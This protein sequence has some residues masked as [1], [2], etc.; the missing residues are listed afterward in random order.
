MT[1]H[2]K[3]FSPEKLHTEEVV[4][5][6]IVDQLVAGQG[7][8]ERPAEAFDQTLGLDR[9]VVVAFVKDTQPQVWEALEGQYPGAAEKEFFRNLEQALK[10]RGTLEV[11]R[12][13]FKMVPNMHF[14]LMFPRPASSLNPD[15]V[16]LYEGNRLTVMTQVVYS[17]RH[18]NAIDIVLFLNGLPVATMEVKNTL[19]S[20]TFR[21]AES[22]YRKDRPPAGEPLLTFKRGALVHFALDQEN[23]SMTT[24]LMNGKTRFLPFN[25]GR[26]GGAGNPDIEGDFA[27]GYLYADQPEGKAIFGREVWIDLMSKFIH[28]DK[29]DG[30]QVMLFPRF[31]QLDCVRKTLAHARAHGPGHNYL[32]Q[33][34]AGSGKSNTIAWLAH[35]AINLHDDQNRP[36]FDT[37]IIITDRLVLDRQLQSTVASFEKTPGVVK[38]I[39]GTSRDLRE[40]IEAGARIIITTI[41]K[42]GTEHLAKLSGVNTRRFAIIIDEAHSSQ[43]GKSN[44]QMVRSLTRSSEDVEDVILEYQRARGPQPNISFFAF[45]ATP[46]PVTLERFGR[47]G[48]DGTPQAFHLYS[49]RQAIE[50]GFI[51]DVLQNYTTYQAYFQLEKAIE[52]DPALRTRDGQRR[53]ARFARL[54]P[55]NIAQ[56]VEV[57]VEHFRRHVMKELNG[58][59]KAMVVTESREHALRYWQ[60]LK[61]Y[62]EKQGYTDLKA[63]VAFSGDLDID[64]QTWSE[65]AANGFS[66]GELPKR[67]NGIKPDGTPYEVQYQVLVVAEK[68]QT[69][70][71]QPKLCAMYVD[72]KLDGLQAVQTLARLNRTYPGK[73]RTF[74]L[75]FRNTLDDIRTAFAPFFE[76]TLLEERTNFNQIYT[77][78][79]QIRSCPQIDM[80]EVEAF[81]AGFFVGR[82]LTSAERTNLEAVVRRARDRFL[83]A[84]DE[85]AMEEFRQFAKSY[86][87][88]Y[89]FVSQVVALGDSNLERLYVYLDWLVRLLPSRSIPAQIEITDDML[90][91]EAYRIEK[92][93]EGSASLV[94]GDGT[95]L[96]PIEEFGASPYTEEEERSLS[97]IVSAFNE[98]HG[99]TFSREDFLRLER[100]NQEILEDEDLREMILNN[101]EDVVRPEFEALFMGA[102]IRMFQRD[103]EMQ[104][105][106]MS[107][108]EAREMAIRHFFRTARRQVFDGARPPA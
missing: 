100:V 12:E 98:R 32:E 41:Q 14:R 59:A 43:S 27:I 23:V 60:G 81:A 64:G 62:I 99:T 48:P 52:D 74:V 20:Q 28:L 39:D 46:R 84:D 85:A 13:G 33:H 61:G 82:Q 70:F 17:A 36:I 24:R 88:F 73:D 45:T 71:D 69:G 77:L 78:E 5:R 3:S 49:M 16:R 103:T 89:A 102:L 91:L 15:L 7:Y 87:R 38:K 83:L 95:R 18:G 94:A 21:H 35:Q 97:E 108:N 47:I 55:T 50:E 11:L 75:D 86:M 37:A 54:H 34:S 93:D 30:K 6:H 58:Q 101:P 56:K 65:E 76:A 104:S 31:Q 90:R 53:V 44:A 92:T 107:D 67:F 2:P 26:D 9:D 80:S 25:R 105:A 8:A 106:V 68:Y 72:K 10:N 40:A 57:I 96:R 42:F 29:S 51:L 63:L 4:E 66:E 22:Q 1:T 19:T 79:A